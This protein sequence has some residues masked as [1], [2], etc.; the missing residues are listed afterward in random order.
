MARKVLVVEDEPSIRNVL[1]V[2]L[3]A[4]KCEGDVAYSGQQ[5]LA[6]IGRGSFD[7]VLLDL[8]CADPSAAEVLS[9]INEIRPNL[10]GRILF[11]TGEVS[12]PGT[13]TMIERNCAPH[14]TQ[15]RLIEDLWD[16]L[17]SIFGQA[18][19]AHTAH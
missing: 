12:D 8:R 10:V 11:I 9:K 6:M 5:A 18:H 19:S 2:L 4:L 15:G 16:R 3:A 17:R 13:L 7:A 1:Y 14:V